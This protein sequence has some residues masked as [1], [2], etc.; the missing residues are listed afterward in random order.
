MSSYRP[1]GLCYFCHPPAAF[2]SCFEQEVGLDNLKRS[3][4]T[5]ITLPP[6]RQ[7]VKSTA[8]GLSGH[9]T[10][11]PHTVTAQEVSYRDF[12]CTNRPNYLLAHW[13]CP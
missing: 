11:V 6:K 10:A 4:P 5:L 13:P 2:L 7:P 1:L 8:E 12:S 3:L 9:L